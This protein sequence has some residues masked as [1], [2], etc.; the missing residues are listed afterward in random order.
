MTRTIL[1]KAVSPALSRNY[2]ANSTDTVAGYVLRAADVAEARTPQQLFDAHGLGFSGS[3]WQRSSET[4]DVIRFQS[5]VGNYLH[6]AVAPEFVDRAPFTGTGLTSWDGGRAPL[7]YL[8]EVRLPAGAEHWRIGRNGSED[9]L[10]VYVDVARGWAVVADEARVE[11]KPVPPSSVLG[12][13][14]SWRG[15][16]FV[17]DMVDDGNT[18]VLSSPGEPPAEVSGFEKT[19]RGVWRAKVPLADV[20]DLYEL[21]V[22]CTFNGLPFRVLDT[23]MD[24]SRRVFRLSYTGH[25]ADFAEGLQLDKA[26]AGVYRAIA[27]EEDVQ[28]LQFVQNRLAGLPGSGR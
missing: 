10:A 19:A 16:E 14:A 25:N 2:L 3:P 28:D 13:R 15:A 26:D 7:F 20:T 9:L 23:A 11:P 8:D 24:G 27:A 4:I 6:D 1:Q 18:V 5:P 12:L 17:A 22:S 21:N